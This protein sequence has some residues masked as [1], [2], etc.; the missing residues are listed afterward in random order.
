[1]TASAGYDLWRRFVNPDFVALL[2][3]LHFGRNYVRASG[4]MLF[5]DAGRVYV[6]MLSGFGV[7]NVGHNHPRVKQALATALRSDVPSLLGVDAPLLTAQLAERLTH[8]MHPTLC[9]TA[10][11]N[12]G[13]EAVDIAVRATCAASNRPVILAA[14]NA[15]H[16]LTSGAASLAENALIRQE[17]LSRSL[18]VEHVP[19]GN[20]EALYEACRRVRPAAF[21]VEP[22]Q[23]EGGIHVPPACYLPEV[24]QVCRET[25][26][27]LVVDEVQTGLGRTG[28]MFA[29][30]F[31]ACVPDI[32]LVG[33]ALGGGFLPV[34]AAVMSEE[35]WQRAFAG[36]TRCRYVTPTL[37]G[38]SLAMAAGLET[39]A[40]IEQEGLAPRAATLGRI[41][42]QRLQRIVKRH[43]MISSARGEGLLAGIEFRPPRG[44]S[45]RV[46]PEWSRELIYPQVIA[47]ALLRD[48]AFIAQTCLLAPRVLRIE[49]PLVIDDH[50]L[51][52]F[53]DSLDAVL[54]AIPSEAKSVVAAAHMRLTPP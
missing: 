36:P 3:M 23:T 5:D 4:A 7:Y 54:T 25:G 42:N 47:S 8:F 17:A 13:A 29:T 30:D 18:T 31:R 48:H 40:V 38:G 24:S 9:R 12:S 2:D 50:A 26:T 39:L 45:M 22:V 52:S 15:F 43:P 1:V 32:V 41:L 37:A 19:F 33:G 20:T 35:V 44:F 11:A 51:L 21:F 6:D 10:F 53:L 34:S 16:G 14:Q 46:V 49:P 27:L 28:A